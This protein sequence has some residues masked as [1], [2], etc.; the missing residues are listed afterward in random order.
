M[1]MEYLLKGIVE[2]NLIGRMSLFF[3]YLIFFI[4][5]ILIKFLYLFVIISYVSF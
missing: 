3:I 5:F 2:L 4:F 1:K